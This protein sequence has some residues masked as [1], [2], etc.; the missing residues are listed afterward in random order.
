MRIYYFGTLIADTDQN[1]KSEQTKQAD[2]SHIDEAL[3]NTGKSDDR[4][5]NTLII[6]DFS[7]A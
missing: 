5:K 7:H 4:P 2:S 1:K 3:A 6:R